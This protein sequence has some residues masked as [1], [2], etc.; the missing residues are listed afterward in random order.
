[1]VEIVLEV[2]LSSLISHGSRRLLVLSDLLAYPLDVIVRVYDEV[3]SYQASAEVVATG[4][5]L[6]NDFLDVIIVLIHH[7]QSDAS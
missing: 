4:V 6:S 2:L 7:S 5:L 1:M 3:E